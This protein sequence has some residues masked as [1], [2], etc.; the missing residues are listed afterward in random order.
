MKMKHVLA[1]VL[2]FVTVLISACSTEEK[3]DAEKQAVEK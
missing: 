3:K 1:V 2:L